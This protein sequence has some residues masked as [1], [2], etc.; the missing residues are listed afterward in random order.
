MAS[1]FDA[2]LV[3][4]S[5]QALFQPSVDGVSGRSIGYEALARG[6]VGSPLPAA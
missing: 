6:P 1:E 5:L 3:A 2:L 4:G